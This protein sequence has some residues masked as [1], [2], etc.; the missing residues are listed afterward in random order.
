[1]SG[2]KRILTAEK[3]NNCGRVDESM[4]Q[5]NRTALEF[6]GNPHAYWASSNLTAKRFVLKATFARPLAYHK[7]EGYRTP[8]LSLP[9][10]LMRDFEQQKAGMVH[11]SG[12]TSNPAIDLIQ[13]ITTLSSAFDT[14]LKIDGKSFT[15]QPL[16]IA[17]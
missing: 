16:A 5:I 14:P 6:L 13:S 12:E 7:H 9:F 17:I 10:S 11:P 15:W 2:E 4:Q 3:I 1:V 8:A